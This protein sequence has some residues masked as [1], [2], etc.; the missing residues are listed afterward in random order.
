MVAT[1]MYFTVTSIL[2]HHKDHQ[3]LIRVRMYFVAK[4]EWMELF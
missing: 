4:T 1:N 2:Y 3:S